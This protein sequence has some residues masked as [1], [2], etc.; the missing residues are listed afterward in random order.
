SQWHTIL[1]R[2]DLLDEA[3]AAGQIVTI[4]VYPYTSSSTTTDVLLPDWA[5]KD[6]RAGLRQAAESPE[7][8]QK[9]H[10]DIA[11]R[12][13]GEGWTDLSFV[14]LAAGRPEWIGKTLTQVPKLAAD[15]NGQIENLID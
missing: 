8:R 3:R 9:L 10:L 12:L 5:L 15:F 7:N 11:T 1:R 13:M 14:R 4:D 2:L 6:N